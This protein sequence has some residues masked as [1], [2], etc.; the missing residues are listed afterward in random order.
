[1]LFD[2]N[3]RWRSESKLMPFW[4]AWTFSLSKKEC[5]MACVRVSVSGS[6]TSPQHACQH[7]CGPACGGRMPSSTAHAHAA[8]MP[9]PRERRLGGYTV[10]DGRTCLE[11]RARDQLHPLCIVELLRVLLQPLL[12]GLI[13]GD[14]I[15]TPST[16]ARADDGAACGSVADR[17][18]MCML[19]YVVGNAA[20]TF[21]TWPC[22][23]SNSAVASACIDGSSSSSRNSRGDTHPSTPTKP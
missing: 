18:A 15:C 4:S 2:V 23:V 20:T 17:C 22:S 8:S 3:G 6:V 21:C 7:K 19:T 16:S 10:Q 12:V 13:P 11:P 5:R 9:Y 14:V 1:M